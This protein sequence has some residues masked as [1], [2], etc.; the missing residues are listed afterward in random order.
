MLGAALTSAGASVG[1]HGVTF[2]GAGA[3][4]APGDVDALESAEVSRGLGALVDIYG[5]N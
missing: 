4:V 1:R 5:Q 3:L 2:R